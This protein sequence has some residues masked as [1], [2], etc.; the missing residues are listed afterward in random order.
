[1]WASYENADADAQRNMLRNISTGHACS[2]MTFVLTNLAY[3]VVYWLSMANKM[4]CK[5]RC[6]RCNGW[7]SQQ[8][9]KWSQHDFNSLLSKQG[10][11]ISTKRQLNQSDFNLR[12]VQRI[13]WYVN[14]MRYWSVWSIDNVWYDYQTISFIWSHMTSQWRRSSSPHEA[15]TT[16]S[17]STELKY[18]QSIFDPIIFTTI[19]C[20]FRRT[21][22]D[23]RTLFITEID[24]Q[25]I[26]SIASK[27]FDKII[28]YRAWLDG[29][30][31]TIWSPVIFHYFTQFG[32]LVGL[33]LLNF[34]G[35]G[36]AR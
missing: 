32:Y 23:R 14:L 33:I 6:N 8:T 30:P 5:T 29:A 20:L 18:I 13:V 10:N 16:K 15:G 31:R 35:F 22:Y 36:R 25:T 7:N 9:E 26:F 11:W 4:D 12:S 3:N 2:T 19:T 24:C 17:T 27:I 34:D 1:M 21:M 28:V